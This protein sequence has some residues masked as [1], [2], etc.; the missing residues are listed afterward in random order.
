MEFILGFLGKLVLLILLVTLV[1][2]IGYLAWRADQPMELPQF[3]GYTYYQYLAWRKDA[4]HQMA[5]NYKTAHP[6]AKMGG[7]LDVCFE[8]CFQEEQ[9]KHSHPLGN[10][11]MKNIAIQECCTRQN[12]IADL[13]CGFR[14]CRT[15]I[16]EHA[17]Q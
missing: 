12:Y 1:V 9:C 4:L 14:A 2:P 10:L 5:V 7:G 8:P 16:P 15:V 3:K 17:A 6:N 13:Y 11:V